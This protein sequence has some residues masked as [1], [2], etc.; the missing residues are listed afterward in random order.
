MNFPATQMVNI[1]DDTKTRNQEEWNILPKG[2]A[3]S[4]EKYAAKASEMEQKLKTL[5]VQ[6]I[7]KFHSKTCFVTISIHPVNLVH[8]DRITVFLEKKEILS[9]MDFVPVKQDKENKALFEDVTIAR[10]TDADSVC[11]QGGNVIVVN[12]PQKIKPVEFKFKLD[13]SVERQGLKNNRIPIF[14]LVY[15]VERYG[16]PLGT[17]Y[18]MQFF[19][20][21]RSTKQKYVED[22]YK[23]L[24]PIPQEIKSSRKRSERED[25]EV[26]LSEKRPRAD[27]HL[28]EVNSP[29]YGTG[30]DFSNLGEQSPAIR[31]WSDAMNCHHQNVIYPM[32][33]YSC[34]GEQSPAIRSLA[35]VLDYPDYYHEELVGTTPSPESF[36]LD[37]PQ[38][39]AL[40]D[41]MQ[42]IFGNDASFGMLF[43]E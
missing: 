42:E 43:Q 15:A 27:L 8:G 5:G 17:I 9:D 2:T 31:L 39:I 20:L 23:A 28:Q 40:F 30:D 26:F 10:N 21:N 19:L 36:S 6:G 41:G 18:G 7:P 16:R 3:E 35:D 1:T 24:Y 12:I 11:D 29:C 32:E 34:D 33:N 22:I 4:K 13:I 38:D 25:E 37:E 14:R